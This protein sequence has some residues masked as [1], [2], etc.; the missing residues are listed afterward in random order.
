MG[1]HDSDGEGVG[2]HT[3]VG[4]QIQLGADLRE[5]RIIINNKLNFDSRNILLINVKSTY[6]KSPQLNQPCLWLLPV[7][8]I[9]CTNECLVIGNLGIVKSPLSE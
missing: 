7:S 9:Q 6:F 8:K 3:L 4:V 2:V 5:K 1:V